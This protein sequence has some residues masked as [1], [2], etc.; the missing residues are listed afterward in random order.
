MRRAREDEQRDITGQ[1]GFIRFHKH[2]ESDPTSEA[3]GKSPDGK[4]TNRNSN[5]GQGEHV[6]IALTMSQFRYCFPVGGDSLIRPI[7]RGFSLFS[8]QIY[9]RIG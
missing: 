9:E 8:L 6:A 3:N 1:P 4:K 7:S 5:Q 2:L